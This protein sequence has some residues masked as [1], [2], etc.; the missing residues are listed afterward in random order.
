MSSAAVVIDALKV[1]NNH[2]IYKFWHYRV[3]P[4]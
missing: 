1:N 4:K 3:Y 2:N